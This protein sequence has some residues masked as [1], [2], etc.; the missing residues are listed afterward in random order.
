M[1]A[2]KRFTSDEESFFMFRDRSPVTPKNMRKLMKIILEREH[3]DPKFY[4]F[5]SLRIGRATDM[6]KNSI[7]LRKIQKLGRRKK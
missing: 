2:R 3:F 7:S 1:T 5:H 4:R 6:E